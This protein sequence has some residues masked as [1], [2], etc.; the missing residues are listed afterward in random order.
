MFIGKVIAEGCDCF[1]TLLW[2]DAEFG[3]VLWTDPSSPLDGYAQKVVDDRK[4]MKEIDDLA[5]EDED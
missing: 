4:A 1:D 3:C 5:V 2:V